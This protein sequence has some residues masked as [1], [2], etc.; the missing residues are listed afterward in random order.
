MKLDKL[1]AL[2]TTDI[3]RFFPEEISALQPPPRMSVAEWVENHRIMPEGSAIPGGKK[4]S[5][6]ANLRI[7]YDWFN[8]FRIKE[9]TCQKPAQCGFTDLIVDLILW[10]CENDPS[11]TALF[12]ADR[13]T[14]VKIMK[15]RI[16][17][18]FR[19]LGH[20]NETFSKKLKKA[21]K[22][23]VNFSNGFFLCV[24]WGSSISQTASM[25]Y[26][27]VFCDEI[28]KPGYELSKDEGNALGRIRERMETYPDS[29]F[30]KF[31]TPTTDSGAVT[32]ELAKAS[33]VYDFQ[34]PCPMCG[35]FNVL[36]F[37]NVK[38]EGG[39]KAT[40]EQIE[41]TSRYVCEH[42][43]AEW[44]TA[45]KNG[46]IPY[47]Q[48][49]PRTEP[50]SI[51][52][53]GLQLHRLSSLFPGGRL[54][55]MVDRWVNAQKEGPSEIQNVI[56]SIFGEPWVNRVTAPESERLT[57]L[58]SC[59]LDYPRGT[60]PEEAVALV[61]GVDV[62]TD[63]FWYQICAVA[64]DLTS[65][66]VAEGEVGT[67]E[68]LE[69]VL[70]SEYDG[71]RIWR[72][73]IDTGGGKAKDKS[74]SRTEETYNFIRRNQQRGMRIMGAKGSSQS[75]PTKIKVGSPID[76]TPSGKPI[77]GGIRIV[78]INT[79]A[80]KDLF[81]WRIEK[82][83]QQEP[84]GRYFHADTFDYVFEQLLSEEKRVDKNGHED[85]VAVKKSNHL[86]D[87][88]VLCLACVDSEF[89][90]G[91]R[92]VAK[93]PIRHSQQQNDSRYTSSAVTEVKQRRSNPY[94]EGI[95]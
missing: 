50:T 78:Q 40:P 64:S 39:H 7:I 57:Q 42:C 82:A 19:E 48:F 1:E 5:N 74:V 86:F 9:I 59:V 32:R 29:K 90:G 69:G 34:I 83:V 73:L 84:G 2:I 89:F 76:K 17:P 77:V 30:I 28:N 65:W 31:S 46:A 49:I 62:Q 12:L 11:P 8:N 43:G 26:K 41:N 92:A 10:I 66:S 55:T 25:S 87:C 61:A 37:K 4:I 16:L 20:L 72:T 18:A 75:M 53:V 47:G 33:V 23:E 81:W 21:T 91:I 79:D 58:H 88:N 71:R 68:D 13:E 36:T 60:V 51:K 24:S 35:G 38:W 52:H 93:P 95:Y 63:S 80:F 22:F 3:S 45:D 67:W 70:Y 56:N 85:W 94:T 27:Y 54:E 15:Y 14:A 44:T 6:S